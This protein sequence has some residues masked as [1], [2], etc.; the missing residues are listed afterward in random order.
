MRDPNIKPIHPGEILRE[1][2]LIP[3]KI[4]TE[5]LAKDLKVEKRIIEGIIAEKKN[6]T[7]DIALRLSL[8]FPQSAQFWLNCQKS[9]EKECLEEIIIKNK[10]KLEKEIFP[11]QKPSSDLDFNY[12]FVDF[13]NR[14]DKKFLARV[15]ISK[16]LPFHE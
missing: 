10:K 5:K 4:S 12:S 11:C 15:E 2:L 9:Y 14:T 7:P 3:L 1:E 6:I 13:S 8:Y 16:Y